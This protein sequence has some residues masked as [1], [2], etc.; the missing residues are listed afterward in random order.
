MQNSR[1]NENTQIIK[2]KRMNYHELSIYQREEQTKKLGYIITMRERVKK[3]QSKRKKGG[4][5]NY[6]PM[7]HVVIVQPSS[8]TFRSIHVTTIIIVAIL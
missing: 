6:Q 3:I 5:R 2:R 1:G 7:Q 8:P 4:A